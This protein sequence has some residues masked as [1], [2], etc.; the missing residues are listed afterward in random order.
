MNINVVK[1]SLI[2]KSLSWLL[3]CVAF[4]LESLVSSDPKVLHFLFVCQRSPEPRGQ[5]TGFCL[6][7]SLKMDNRQHVHPRILYAFQEQ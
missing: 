7:S 3:T 5:D 2:G 1:L 6:C 4:H